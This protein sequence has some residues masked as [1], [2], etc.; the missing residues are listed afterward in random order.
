MLPTN[1]VMRREA[2]ARAELGGIV[3]LPPHQPTDVAFEDG[4][5]GRAI[6]RRVLRI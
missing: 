4:R 3:T 5:D 1:R 2:D 6:G